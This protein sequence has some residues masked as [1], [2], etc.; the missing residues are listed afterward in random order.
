MKRNSI[1]IIIALIICIICTQSVHAASFDPDHIG[2]ISLVLCTIKEDTPV[3]GAEF[4]VY[5]VADCVLIEGEDELRYTLT[6]DFEDADI[7]LA[8]IDKAETAE[9][10]SKY[11]LDTGLAPAGTG[12]TD[13]DGRMTIG[14][15]SVGLYLV[16]QTNKLEKYTVVKPFFIRVGAIENGDIEYDM[17]A[18]PKVEVR[19][20]V[21]PPGVT[22]TPAPGITPTPTPGVPPTVTPTPAPKEPTLAQTGQNKW[23][24]PFLACIGMALII[25]GL[26]IKTKKDEE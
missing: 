10:A 7:D 17:D 15:L 3:E 11:A 8:R 2:S 23:Q 14:G 1:F 5:K 4:A 13:S 20:M 6:S 25:E 26:V 9:K 12:E 18:T 19:T 21:P 24:I 22:P 16:V